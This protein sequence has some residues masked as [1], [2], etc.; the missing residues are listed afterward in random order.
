MRG[1]TLRGI[2]G[3]LPAHVVSNEEI[4]AGLGVSGEWIERRTGI[5]ERRRVAPGTAASDLAVAAAAPLIEQAT[6][7]VQAVVVATMSPDHPCPATAPLGWWRRVW[8]WAVWPRG[9]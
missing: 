4:G 6:N 7:P 8:D 5:C 1:V 9:M 3:W 2:S